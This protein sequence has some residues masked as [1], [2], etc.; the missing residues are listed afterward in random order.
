MPS[1]EETVM[2]VI[3]LSAHK[4]INSIAVYHSSSFLGMN[5]R[6]DFLFLKQGVEKGEST[7]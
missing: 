7:I 2:K 4:V 1:Q 5:Y 3:N 6:T